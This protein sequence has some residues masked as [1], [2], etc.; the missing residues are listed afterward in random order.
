MGSD[1][2]KRLQEALASMLPH[3]QL[4]GMARS[5]DGNFTLRL[6]RARTQLEYV[7]ETLG[8]SEELERLE[9][10][11]G[12]SL[13]ARP[14]ASAF[15]FD[16]VGVHDV[17]ADEGP[18][19]VYLRDVAGN[20]KPN[21][22]IIA[23]IN[24]KKEALAEAASIRSGAAFRYQYLSSQGART[25]MWAACRRLAIID[26]SAEPVAWGSR[27]PGGNIISPH[28]IDLSTSR[29]L[30]YAV[31]LI[32]SAVHVALVPLPTFKY[33]HA[34]P[35]PLAV[36]L[37]SS[38]RTSRD[39]GD[40]VRTVADAVGG[41]ITLEANMNASFIRD[42][43]DVI[44]RVLPNVTRKLDSGVRVVSARKLHSASEWSL[45]QRDTARRFYLL[46]VP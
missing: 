42:V 39:L 9:S 17:C 22:I 44:T 16:A 1:A 10:V 25:N 27:L 28:A 2:A 32:T 12:S 31:H 29:G 45:V 37:I 40:A 21:E 18:F 3:V 4:G 36:A 26:S 41:N 33:S 46:R 6:L 38:G 20:S 7:V 19:E 23:I 43:G 34:N 15:S 13:R 5:E 14:G 30:G 8:R 35:P 24:M 11:I